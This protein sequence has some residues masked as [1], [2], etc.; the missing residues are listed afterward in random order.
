MV[1]TCDQQLYK[2]AVNITWAYPDQFHNFVLRLGGM[3]FVMD[4]IE[5]VGTLMEHTGLP[6]IM[7][8]AFGGFFF[9]C[10]RVAQLLGI[11]KTKVVKVLQAGHQLLELG[12]T[13]AALADVIQES[14]TFIVACY[15]HVEAVTMTDVRFNV[16]KVKTA[17]AKIASAPKLMSLPPTNESFH[18]NVLRAH[19]QCCIWKHAAE[20]KPPEIDP[21]LHGW[22]RDTVNKTLQPTML[23]PNTSAAPH[24]SRPFSN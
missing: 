14:T 21:T 23:P 8:R 4:F 20:P 11:G 9:T 22:Y 12:N 1:F 19:L 24:T 7:E 18:Q 13:T 10:D 2:V 5:C 6:D 17:N 3:H 15:G 16:R